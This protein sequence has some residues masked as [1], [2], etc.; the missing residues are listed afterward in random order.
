LT[1]ARRPP[2]GRLLRRST[3][4]VIL[5]AS[6][7]VRAVGLVLIIAVDNRAVAGAAA[8]LGG[9]GAALGFPVAI[10]AA[11]GRPGEEAGL[12]AISVSPAQG[13]A[14]KVSNA[15]ADRVEGDLG[16]GGVFGSIWTTRFGSAT[17]ERS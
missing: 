15:A 5:C 16:G 3:R 4:P 1:S 12:P 9:L 10:S 6:A 8:L 14:N 7:L 17:Q 11:V 2:G 13:Y